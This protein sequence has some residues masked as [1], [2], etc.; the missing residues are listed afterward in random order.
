MPASAAG[1]LPMMQLVIRVDGRDPYHVFPA[2]A[3]RIR[4]LDPAAR[5][6]R[7]RSVEDIMADGEAALTARARLLGA[8]GLVALTIAAFGV[9]TTTVVITRRRQRELA[10]R[11]ALGATLAQLRSAHALKVLLWSLPGVIAGCALAYW[12]ALSL[13]PVLF[14]VAPAD[15]GIYGACLVGLLAL[16][17]TAAWMATRDLRRTDIVRSVAAD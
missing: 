8:A 15:P 12:G 2:I 9:S 11:V 4:E 7:V 13:A 5:I 6:P 3:A 16:I 14:G 10:I 1:A 17:A